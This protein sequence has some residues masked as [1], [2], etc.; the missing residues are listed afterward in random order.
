MSRAAI[1]L[2]PEWAAA[3]AWLDKRTEN[4]LWQPDMAALGPG[5]WICIHAGVTVG[6]LPR[7]LKGREAFERHLLER[8]HALED[9]VEMAEEAGWSPV[10]GGDAPH[11]ML[12]GTCARLAELVKPGPGEPGAVAVPAERILLPVYGAVVAIARVVG[13]DRDQRTAWDVPGEWHWRLDSVKRLRT[14]VFCRGQRSVWQLP[15][16][17]ERAVRAQLAS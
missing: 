11:D 1:T 15:E 14:P 3:I 6:G 9:V 10:F 13:A 7:P 4:R 5:R 17:V 8:E 16:D 2:W 12:S